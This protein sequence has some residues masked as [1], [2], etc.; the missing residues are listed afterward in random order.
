MSQ[1]SGTQWI[2]GAVLGA[3]LTVLPQLSGAQSGDG[4]GYLFH[5]PLAALSFR[6][7][8][9]Q[10][11]ASSRVFDFTSQQLTLSKADFL[12]FSGGADLEF[13][14]TPRLGILM[15]VSASARSK[16]SNY[17]NFVDNNDQEIE[18]STSFR[19]ASWTTGLKYYFTKP[20][21][22]I[23]RFAWVP[24]RVT[25]Y[26]TAGAGVMYY[27]FRQSG[28]FVDFSDNGVFNTT[29][30]SSG[31]TPT[32]YGSAGVQ[33]SLSARMSLITEARYDR[34]SAEMSKDFQG[35]DRIDLSGF[36]LSTGLHLR[37]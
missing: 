22:S 25:P 13:T 8:A 10:P 23:S 33:Y 14:P 6:I 20:G 34:A 3:A 11:T 35:F 5:T 36:A 2:V 9:A 32:A 18:Q 26:V 4:D 30:E 7:G 27:G 19:R 31:W 29:L 21:R 16:P 17:R 24:N 1:R 37:F 12:G 15:G 28:D